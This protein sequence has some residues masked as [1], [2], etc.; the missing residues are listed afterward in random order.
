M[1][2]YKELKAKDWREFQKLRL[3]ALQ[4]C[5]DNFASSFEEEVKN[6]EEKLIKILDDNYIIG[7]FDHDDL[8]AMVAFYKLNFRRKIEHKGIIWGLYLKKTYR[9]NGIASELL[10]ENIISEVFTKSCNVLQ[11]QLSVN[12]K[13]I[14]AINLYKK[15]GFII[16]GTELESIKIGNNFHDEYLMYLKLK[17]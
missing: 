7:A 6:T 17:K 12:T 2:N 1:I 4:E 16:Y 14:K 13:N 9:S 5:P 3:E 8:I 11:V 15:H 10:N